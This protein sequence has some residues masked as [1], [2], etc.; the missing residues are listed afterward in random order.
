MEQVL[1]RAKFGTLRQQAGR[2]SVCVCV[3]MLCKFPCA[4]ASQQLCDETGGGVQ[5]PPPPHLLVAE[6]I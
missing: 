6:E 4:D 3:W 5:T 2:V 1:A